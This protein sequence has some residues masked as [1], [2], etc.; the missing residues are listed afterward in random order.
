MKNFLKCKISVN[1][2]NYKSNKIMWYSSLFKSLLI[3]DCNKIQLN[4]Y[5]K[6]N[7]ITNLIPGEA[8]L[9]KILFFLKTFVS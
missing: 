5:D 7:F 3:V 1:Y 6:L 4:G 9:N 2:Y 8:G